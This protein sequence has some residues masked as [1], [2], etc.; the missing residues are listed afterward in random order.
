[1][2]I[3]GAQDATRLKA[4]E[5]WLE[6]GNHIEANE[7]LEKI[8]PSRRAHPD[9]LQVRYEIYAKAKRWEPCLDIA[10]A[11]V[12]L[13][14]ERSFGWIRRAKA[15]HGLNRTKEALEA[16]LP[17][18]RRFPD[19]LTIRYDLACYEC[20]LGNIAKAKRRLKEA[21]RI[22]QKLD[23]FDKWRKA[24]F[25]EPDLLPMRDVYGAYDL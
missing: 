2:K 1:V 17:A 11:I 24:A 9:V 22:A 15:L 18:M 23:S 3:L 21:Y 5:G 4:A 12:K 19:E 25:L 20:V 10:S 14:P 16:L 7:E 13:D 6:L 8:T